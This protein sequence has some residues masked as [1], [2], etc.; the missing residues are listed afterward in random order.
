MGHKSLQTTQ[1]YLHVIDED[2]KSVGIRIFT[3][4]IEVANGKLT[5][6]EVGGH[7]EFALSRMYNTVIS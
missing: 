7:H 4:I 1:Q 3:E 5:K 6:A 2:L